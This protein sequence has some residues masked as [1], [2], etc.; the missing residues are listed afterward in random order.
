MPSSL[1]TL[2]CETDFVAKSDDFIAL[3]E[4]LGGCLLTCPEDTGAEALLKATAD[5]RSFEQCITDTVSKTGEKTE[6]GDYVRYAAGPTG[7]IGAYVH[8]NHRVG[9]MVEIEASDAATAE[10]V[11]GV[12]ADIAM[13]VTAMKP[14]AVDEDAVDPEVLQREREIARDQSRTN[15]RT[16]WTRSSR[17]R[18]VSFSRTTAWC[19]RRLSRTTARRCSRSWTPRRAV[20]GARPKSNDSFDWKSA[21]RSNRIKHRGFFG[22]FFVDM[23]RSL[24]PGS[25]T[26]G[27]C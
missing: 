5:G 25:S 8:F 4:T 6:I 12:A 19:I 26:N 3:A 20:R 9:A 23:G 22:A 2:C 16:S 13:H 21:D 15:R 14:V 18:S 11:Q 17:A 7:V 1:A 27:C 10:A 24:W